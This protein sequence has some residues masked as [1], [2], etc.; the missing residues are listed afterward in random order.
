MVAGSEGVTFLPAYVSPLVFNNALR[1]SIN[2]DYHFGVNDGPSILHEFGASLLMRFS[3]GHPFTR[4]VGAADLEG[5]PRGRVPVESLNAS[6]TPS[7]FQVDLRVD[8]TFN[9]FDR[10]KLNV[11]LF[12]IN[13][14]DKKNVENVFLRTG[15]NTDDGFISNPQL[16]GQLVN[17]AGY[18]E[19]YRAINIDY[20]QQYQQ[21]A[22]GYLMTNP[23]FWGPPRQ[24]R[25]GIRLEY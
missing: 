20:Y 15:S 21:V 10:I 7:T 16:S 2:L 17:Q 8:K 12:V 11:Y 9:L 24:I 1:G 19:M 6:V 14:F 25:L 5:N 18:T 13:L 23:N 3:S 4:G 22:N